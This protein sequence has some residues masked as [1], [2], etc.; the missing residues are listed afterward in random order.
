MVNEDV[1]YKGSGIPQAWQWFPCYT[2]RNING[3]MPV[4]W[5]NGNGNKH[6]F[7]HWG[8]TNVLTFC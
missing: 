7:E 4:H 3:C 1:I 8:H 5:Y 2:N 6:H